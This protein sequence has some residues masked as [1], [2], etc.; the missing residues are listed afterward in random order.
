M[1]PD[2]L[3]VPLDGSPFAAA[4]VPIAASCMKAAGGRLVLVTT[5]WHGDAVDPRQYLA[6]VAET[7]LGVET[8]T[9]VIHDRP[10]AE[11]IHVV[12]DEEPDRAVCMTTHGRGRLR[13]AAL[14]SVAE[15]VIHDA[16]RPVLLVG[17]HCRSAESA[18]P[19]RLLV[20]VD[21][22]TPEPSVLG[23]A[24]EWAEALA[25]DVGV[26]AVIHPLDTIALDDVLTS[27]ARTIETA[28][29]RAHWQIVRSSYPAGA[30]ADLAADHH[31]ALIAMGSHAR[32]GAARLALGSVTMG[33]VGLAACPVLVVK[34]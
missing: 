14:G 1:F 30:L 34:E 29:V 23:P 12:V 22:S 25:L 33:V 13:W 10:P 8:Q 3:V 4:A 2:T 21:G 6:G 18:P 17:P 20:C 11:A 5:R 16:S 24:I 9:I 28:G 19:G 31:V 32:T 15:Q 26:V 7:V 27:I